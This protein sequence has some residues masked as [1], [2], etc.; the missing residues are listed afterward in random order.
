MHYPSILNDVIGPVMRGPSSSHCAAALRIGRMARDLMDGEI[1]EVL[2]EFDA[3]GSLATTHESQGSDMGLVG[4]LLGWDA[5]DERLAESARW[6]SEAGIRVETRVCDLGAEH[7]NTYQL[8]LSNPTERHTLTAISTGGG[9]IEVVAIDG[10]PV[11]LAGDY[12]ETLLYLDSGDA[13]LLSYLREHVDAD[14]IT[15]RRGEGAQIIEIKAQRFLDP[16]VAVVLRSQFGIE[17]LKQIAPVLPVLSRRNMRVPFITCAEMLRYNAGLNL[18]LWELALRYESAR[19]HLSEGQVFERMAELVQLMHASILRGI[20]GTQYADRILGY[21][22]G[23]YR[24][25]MDEGRL[26]DGG[27]LNRII[28]YVTAMM[29][30]KSA[31]GMIV[32]APTAGACG[33]L[34]G[35]CIGAASEMGLSPEEMT[36]GMLAAGMIGVFIAAGATFAAE[37]GG[38]Q[39]ECGAGSGMAAAA[40]VTLAKGTAG[41]AVTAASMAL[42]N[43]L[44]MICDPVANRVE[45]PCLG[46]NV[47]AASN[48]LA[49]ANMA[50]AGYDP[51]IPLD[52]VIETMD[53]VGKAIP[54]ELRCT[55]LG[56]LSV[57]R[58]SREIELKLNA[59]RTA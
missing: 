15:L 53:R 10:V 52:E 46:K 29:E 35:A 48:A 20:E 1:D 44:G 7:P 17:F 31:M 21:Q 58:T 32:A 13:E 36:R 11:S 50:L 8:T 22:S 59:Q 49:C 16:D 38:C 18:D 30:V 41:Q 14:E 27:M 6:I 43:I 4:G 39:A 3:N 5:T 40:L 33:G 34:P 12:F 9:I 56:G 2:V 54:R 55:G 47:M 51:V 28:L 45:A 26:L 42:Q 25:R 24:A 37:T 57:T 19:G 23:G